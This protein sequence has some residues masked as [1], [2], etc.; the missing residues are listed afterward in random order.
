M[1]E[2]KKKKGELMTFEN[3]R[4]QLSRNSLVSVKNL[5]K[6]NDII[7][8]LRREINAMKLDRLDS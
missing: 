5:S 8:E 3:I 2:L 1:T 6:I 4:N 7:Y